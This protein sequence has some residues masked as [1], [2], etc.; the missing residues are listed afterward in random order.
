MICDWWISIQ[1]ECFF[2]SRCIACD[3]NCDSLM[4]AKN[5]IVKAAFELQSWLVF[6]KSRMPDEG[7]FS[8]W[9]RQLRAQN[10]STAKR[11]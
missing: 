7:Y 1:F 9:H 2:V 11:S 8:Q 5:A 6:E 3:R 10:L 4:V